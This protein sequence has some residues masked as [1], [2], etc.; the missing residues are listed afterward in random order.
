MKFV[1]AHSTATLINNMAAVEAEHHGVAPADVANLTKLEE[2]THL[3]HMSIKRIGDEWVYEINDTVA[4]N[5][6]HLYARVARVIVPLVLAFKAPIVAFAK[7]IKGLKELQPHA[8]EIEAQLLEPSLQARDD[9]DAWKHEIHH[10]R[11]RNIGLN[12]HY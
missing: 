5:I 10:A 9:E 11:L 3:K 6:I 8:D 7:G 1:I 12:T 2:I 4:L